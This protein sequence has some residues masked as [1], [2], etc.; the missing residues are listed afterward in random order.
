M[1][2]KHTTMQVRV[3]A[4]A[5]LLLVSAAATSFSQV[6]ADD[7]DSVSAGVIL[8]EPT[9][10]SIKLWLGDVSALDIAL[11][12]SFTDNGAFYMNVDYLTHFFDVFS[13]APDRLPLYA[14]VGGLF[15]LRS[16]G[17]PPSSDSDSSVR[18]AVRVPLGIS[19]LP[20]EVPIDLFF[21]VAPA[22]TVFPETGFGL[23]GAIGVRYRF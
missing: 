13:T 19:F 18:L 9:G 11:A 16:G 6:S 12:W 14:G 8:G 5:V 20:A 22:L 21:E 17:P 1:M 4:L 2:M 10:L 15:R 23:G 3:C 7:V